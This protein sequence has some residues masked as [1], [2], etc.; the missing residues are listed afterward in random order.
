MTNFESLPLWAQVLMAEP[1]AESTRL[2][3]AEAAAAAVV[4]V[5]RPAHDSGR[6]WRW[7]WYQPALGSED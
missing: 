7:R 1:K 4:R 2:G 3:A 5:M 6:R